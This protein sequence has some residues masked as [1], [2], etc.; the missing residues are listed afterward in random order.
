MDQEVYPEALF[1]VSDEVS[2][3]LKAMAS[4]ARLQILCLLYEREHS[5]SELTARVGLSQPALSQHLARLRAERL[6]TTRRQAQT[7]YYA[8]DSERVRY[9]LEV[10][11]R[12]YCG[13]RAARSI[14]P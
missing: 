11:H 14:R 2:R 13:H 12:L 7:V 3:L 10:L 5:V 4:E 6:V 1:S 8:L 9:L